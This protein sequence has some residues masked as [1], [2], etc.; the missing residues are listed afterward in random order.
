LN[1]FQSDLNSDST[2]CPSHLLGGIKALSQTLRGW[3]QNLDSRPCPA[4]VDPQKLVSSFGSIH[5]VGKKFPSFPDKFIK[6]NYKYSPMPRGQLQAGI[7]FRK[8]PL[9]RKKV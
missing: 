1:G 6:I 5:F 4:S 7:K 3:L 9:R 2:L 8:S